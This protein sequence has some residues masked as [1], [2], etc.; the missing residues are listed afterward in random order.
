MEAVHS[1]EALT[2]IDIIS[3]IMS[4]KAKAKKPLGR[5]KLELFPVNR[6]N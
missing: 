5:R 4:K 3:M 6:M 2:F 1:R